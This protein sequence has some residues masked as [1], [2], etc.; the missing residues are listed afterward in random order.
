MP[1]KAV[2]DIINAAKALPTDAERRD[3]FA[4]LGREPALDRDIDELVA[5]RAAMAAIEM[6]NAQ[7]Q[8][9]LAFREAVD[10]VFVLRDEAIALGVSWKLLEVKK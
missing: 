6:K 4:S 8:A 1:S 9:A 5:E 3:L 2:I 10:R 7:D